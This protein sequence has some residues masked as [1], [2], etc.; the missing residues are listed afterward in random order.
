LVGIH[1]LYADT[2][3]LFIENFIMKNNPFVLGGA[4]FLG[5]SL[6]LSLGAYIPSSKLADI[7]FNILRGIR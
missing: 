6:G 3:L 2:Y 5:L 4:I 1:K 7:F